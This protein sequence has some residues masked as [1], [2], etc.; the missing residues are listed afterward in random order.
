MQ[1]L[2]FHCVQASGRLLIGQPRSAFPTV[3]ADKL[4]DSKG[5]L[6][7]AS[8]LSSRPHPRRFLDQLFL[9]PVSPPPSFGSE[10]FPRQR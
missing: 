4:C 2:Y 3:A 10:Y 6:K 8:A 7:L 9:L 5:D 1:Q